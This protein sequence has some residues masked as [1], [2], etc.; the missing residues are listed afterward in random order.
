MNSYKAS[1]PLAS[2]RASAD[3]PRRDF[4]DIDALAD[5]IRATGGQPVNPVVVVRDGD[6]Y[7]LVDGERRF[8]ALLKIHGEGGTADALVFPDYPEAHAA[9]AMLATDDKRPLTDE[10]RARGFQTMLRLDVGE[11]D[12]TR[13]LGVPAKVVRAARRVAPLAGEQATLDQMAKAAEFDDPDDQRAVLEADDWRKAARDVAQA[14]EREEAMAP[15]RECLAELGIKAVERA[16]VWSYTSE[17]CGTADEIRDFAKRHE[18]ELVVAQELRWS[19]GLYFYAPAP[20]EPPETEEQRAER[21]RQDRMR[22]ATD[23]LRRALVRFVVGADVTPALAVA[24]VPLRRRCWGYDVTSVCS[25]LE[26][27]FDVGEGDAGAMADS[28]MSAFE[29]CRALRDFRCRREELADVIWA[30]CDD[31]FEPSTEDAWLVQ[32][33]MHGRAAAEGAEDAGE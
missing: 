15:L 13:S 27:E 14:R 4:G 17:L 32:Q 8:R 29:L 20:E 16:P 9:V 24:A 7:R 12:I 23:A 21:E 11:E 33:V 10:E 31:G 18:G 6:V 3:N 19:H 30:A 28:P 25:T 2:V 1:I 22:E 26:S 5:R